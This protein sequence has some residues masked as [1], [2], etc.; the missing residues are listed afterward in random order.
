MEAKEDKHQEEE[1]KTEVKEEDTRK[2]VALE[3]MAAA[4]VNPVEAEAE[5]TAG[6]EVAAAATAEIEEIAAK[7]IHPVE[8]A[9]QAEVIHTDQA[10]VVETKE[11]AQ[12]E[13]ATVE[14][15]VGPDL[16]IDQDHYH[17]QAEMVQKDL[18]EFLVLNSNKKIN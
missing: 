4:A 2:L 9:G 5:E 14:V 12:T 18:L 13:T 17:G 6:E 11:Q 8:T 7:K 3:L 15:A 16:M 1:P 10:A